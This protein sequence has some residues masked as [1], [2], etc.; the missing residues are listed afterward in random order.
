MESEVKKVIKKMAKKVAPGFVEIASRTRRIEESIN[1]LRTQVDAISKHSDQRLDRLRHLIAE[2]EPYQ[3]T[4]GLSG[5]VDNP[6]RTSRERCRTI[7]SALS[8]I[9]G[10]RILD[11]GSSLGFFSFYFADRGSV[12]QGWE[13][14]VKNAEVARLV[15]EINGIDVGFKTKEFNS[16]TVTTI[17]PGAFD[18][19][20]ILSVFHHIIRFKGLK[21][22]QELVRE[23]MERV[24]VL[25]VELA[26]KGED[27]SLPWDESQPEDELAIFDLVREDVVIKKLGDFGNHLS[28]KTRP[29]YIVSMKRQVKVN[30]HVYQY[31]RFSTAA[32]K[33]SPVTYRPVRRKYYFSESYVIKEYSFDAKSKQENVGQILNEIKVFLDIQQKNI[34]LHNAPKMLDFSIEYPAKAMVVIEKKPGIL[35]SDASGVASPHAVCTVVKDVLKTLAGLETMKLYHNDVRTWNIIIGEKGSASLIDYGLVGPHKTDDDIVSLLW[36]AASMLTEEREPYDMNKKHLPS[37]SVFDG[38]GLEGLYDQIKKGERSPTKLQE[39]L[40]K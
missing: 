9:A 15:G 37:E 20:F 5:I 24:P 12:V 29:L 30:S 39:A 21:Y 16:D 18:A 10:K 6:L 2:V 25:I 19:A 17:E 22:T 26:K 11:I 13:E 36:V 23:L 8:P 40:A 28:S 4:Y 3:P 7:E 31:E 14:N 34:D 38:T 35:L 27:T 32:Y 33:D 1:A